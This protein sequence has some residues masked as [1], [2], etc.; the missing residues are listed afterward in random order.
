MNRLSGKEMRICSMERD[1][2]VQEPRCT[3]I[4]N[5]TKRNEKMANAKSVV[6]MTSNSSSARKSLNQTLAKT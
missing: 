2:T 5:H 3:R 1:A 4:Q 6:R